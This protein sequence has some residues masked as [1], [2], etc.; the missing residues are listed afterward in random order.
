M[1]FSFLILT[2]LNA[3]TG[4]TIATISRTNM[5]IPKFQ[6][7]KA[8]TDQA[9]FHSVFFEGSTVSITLESELATLVGSGLNF[10]ILILF[11]GNSDITT[12][13]ATMLFSYSNSSQEHV[14]WM[15]N[16]PF[17][18]GQNWIEGFIGT[19]YQSMGNLIQLTFIEYTTL[20]YS[21]TQ[22]TA[23]PLLSNTS[24]SDFSAIL[25]EFS[26][27]IPKVRETPTTI[28]TTILPTKPTTNP[29]T[30]PTTS[31][32]TISEKS[33]TSEKSKPSNEITSGFVSLTLVLTAIPIILARKLQ[34]K[35]E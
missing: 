26:N 14:H 32:R 5:S 34:R 1:V 18:G 16:D 9:L 7:S 35:H 27:L 4:T 24:P 23:L 33:E 12:W 19:H 31:Q 30:K 3:S 21:E 6:I 13:E 28:P 17:V 15:L 11:E 29:T 25:F 8:T 2:F 22:I 20:G 10:Y